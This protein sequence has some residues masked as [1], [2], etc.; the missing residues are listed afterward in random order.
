MEGL[1]ERSISKGSLFWDYTAVRGEL[2]T[3]YMIISNHMQDD[4]ANQGC[5]H[6]D[7]K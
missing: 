3:V 7:A 6:E 5:D 1:E 2:K 4:E